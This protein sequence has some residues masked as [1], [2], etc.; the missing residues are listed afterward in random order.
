MA[1]L[2]R[3]IVALTEDGLKCLPID[4]TVVYIIKDKNDLNLFVGVASRG[5]VLTRIEDHLPKGSSTLRGGITVQIQ[6]QKTIASA[7][8][9]ASEIIA[10]DTPRY[11]GKGNPWALTK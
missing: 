1:E 8:E 7:I 11:N 9:M 5:R 3:K 4:K 2:K 6:Q 10:R